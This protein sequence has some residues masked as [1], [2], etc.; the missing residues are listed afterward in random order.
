MQEQHN[1]RHTNDMRT[2]IYMCFVELVLRARGSEDLLAILYVASGQLPTDRLPTHQRDRLIHVL[3]SEYRRR[4]NPC[5]NCTVSQL[6]AE[7]IRLAPLDPRL[8]QS[9]AKATPV[10]PRLPECTYA[11]FADNG[12]QYLAMTGCSSGS[13]FDFPRLLV[14]VCLLGSQTSYG[15]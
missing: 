7:A 1:D 6:V 10:A 4:A 14:S 11:L 15:E 5:A 3:Q 13:V 8:Q 2:D 12:R 9:V